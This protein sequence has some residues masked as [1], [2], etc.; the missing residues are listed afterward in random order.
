MKKLTFNVQGMTCASCEVLLERKLKQVP[1]VEKV[2][3]SKAKDQVEIKCSDEAQVTQ[4]HQ[5][6]QDAVKDKG[7]TLHLADDSSKWFNSKLITKDKSHW[8][9]IGSVLVVM[10][11]AYILLSQLDILPKNLGVTENMSY[12]LVFLIGL[13][14]AMS[15]CLAVAGGL[16][17]AVVGKYNENNQNLT[18]VQK[19][20]P[21]LFFNAGRII[22]YTVLGGAIGSLGSVLTLSPQVTGTITIIASILMIIIGLQLLNVFPWLNKIQVKM[23]KFIAHKVYGASEQKEFKNRNAFLFG[24]ATFF[25]PCGFTQALQLYVLG[26]G[27]WLTGALTMLAFSLG[28][29]PALVTIGAFTSFTKGTAQKY[30]TIFSALLVVALG[31][32]NLAPGWNLTGASI[33]LPDGGNTVPD[34]N[35]FNIVDGKQIISLKVDG[36][37]YYPDT[38]TLKKGVPV[39]WRIDGSKAQGCAQIISVP[40]LGI[41]EQLPRNQIKTISFTPTETGKIKFSCGMG[42]AGP[43]VFEVVP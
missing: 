5:Q 29:L 24:A 13:V 15:T 43:G 2:K 21:H 37:D 42:M 9:E 40:R 25:L 1:G 32:F 10:I 33:G 6:L 39:E 23:P 38:F 35:D 22:S 26:T 8:T 11:G 31:I 3:A 19:F 4:L 12:G 7:Y 36:F 16:L 18:A 28:T 27:S 14:A 17:L 34:E 41:T 20:R 30:F